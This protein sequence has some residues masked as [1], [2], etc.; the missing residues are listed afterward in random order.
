VDRLRIHDVMFNMVHNAIRYTGEG[1]RITIGADILGGKVH[2][3]VKDTGRGIT[4]DDKKKVFD[5]FF[6]VDQ[7]LVR[8]DGRVGIGLYVSREIVRKHGGDMWFE[9]KDGAGSTFHFTLPLKQR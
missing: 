2:M 7:G 4:E 9:S 5:R 3:W 1:G 6:L 8:E